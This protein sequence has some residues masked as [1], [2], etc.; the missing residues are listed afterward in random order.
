MFD[1]FY[2]IVDHSN[3]LETFLPLGVKCVQLRIK[4][5]SGPVLRQQIRKARELCEAHDCKLIINDHWRLAIDEGCQW[6][7]LGQEDLEA[8]DMAVVKAAG[9][10][11]GISTHDRSELNRALQFQPDYIAL[12]PVYQTVLKKMH[13]RAQGLDKL[14]RWKNSIGD[15]PLVAIGGF[16][17]DRSSGAFDHGADS[18]CVVTDVLLHADPASRVQEW[19]SVTQLRPAGPYT[20]Q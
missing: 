7:H 17:P 12:G 3:W 10:Q 6:I 5:Q 19:L 16:T 2:L 13:W 18:V 20:Q 9:I 14:R 1:R 15:T 4:D 11:F 8:A